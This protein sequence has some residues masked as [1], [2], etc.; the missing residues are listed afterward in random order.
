MNSAQ[1]WPVFLL[2]VATEICQSPPTLIATSVTVMFVCNCTIKSTMWYLSTC[3]AY[4]PPNLT[5][6][7]GI[8]EGKIELHMSFVTV[9]QALFFWMPILPK[10]HMCTFSPAHSHAL[11]DA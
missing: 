3:K 9:N 6:Q 10:G 7:S 4:A 2:F 1:D 8:T 11:T 5:I